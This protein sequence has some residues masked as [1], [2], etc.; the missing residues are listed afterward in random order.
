[1]PNDEIIEN[2]SSDAVDSG[3]IM[4]NNV[5]F[6]LNDFS[7]MPNKISEWGPTAW[8]SRRLAIVECHHRD[9]HR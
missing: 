5:N 1:M 4:K 8:A 2:A 3:N 6:P 7:F 9:D